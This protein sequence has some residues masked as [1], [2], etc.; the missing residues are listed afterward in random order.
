[1]RYIYIF[2]F[3]IVVI[4]NFTVN[5][6]MFIKFQFP[7]AISQE[8]EVTVNLMVKL[9]KEQYFEEQDR[10]IYDHYIECDNTCCNVTDNE[11]YTV[12]IHFKIS[13]KVEHCRVYHSC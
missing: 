1:M 9:E 2:C 13:Y 8:F 5:L 11:C 7:I 4:V 10:A 3:I 12:F 6:V